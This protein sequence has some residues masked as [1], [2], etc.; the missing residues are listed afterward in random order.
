MLASGL[1]PVS[2]VVVVIGLMCLHRCLR[3]AWK[4]GLRSTCLLIERSSDHH[5]SITSRLALEG[6]IPMTV[7]CSHVKM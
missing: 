4:F 7:A 6:A 2:R 5:A 1:E 3:R